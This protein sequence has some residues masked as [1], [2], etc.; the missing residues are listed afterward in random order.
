MKYSQIKAIKKFCLALASEPGWREVV[1]N[2]VNFESDFEV[3]NVRFISSDCIDRIQQDELGSDLYCLGC[4]T[5]HFL[6]DVL[7]I[8]VDVIE[9]MQQAEAYEALGKLIISLG[10]LPALQS[11]Y[12]RLDGYGHHFNSYD[13]GE[14]ELM[15]DG[16]L[17][18]VF[19][20][21]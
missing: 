13:F 18:Y 11:E 4:F 12:S 14:E 7:E 16:T 20:N 21:R 3:D 2:L 9:A 1:E 17:F 15:V 10:K 6:A 8:D 5:D 19:D